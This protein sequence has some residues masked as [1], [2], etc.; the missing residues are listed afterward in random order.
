MFLTLYYCQVCTQRL[1][2][3][4]YVKTSPVEKDRFES[5]TANPLS[6]QILALKPSYV[7]FTSLISAQN[8]CRLS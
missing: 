8:I 7:S 4:G 3:L 1:T 2:L 6:G 5:E